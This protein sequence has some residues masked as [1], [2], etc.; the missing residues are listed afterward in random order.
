MSVIEAV[1]ASEMNGERAMEQFN[2]GLPTALFPLAPGTCGGGDIMTPS[3]DYQARNGPFQLGGKVTVNRLDDAGA[4]IGDSATTDVV[5]TA[6]L[7]RRR[8]WPASRAET[9]FRRG[10]LLQG[11]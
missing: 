11:H 10:L 8:P 5:P 2:R 4:E 9:G 1:S 6:P 3:H 7:P